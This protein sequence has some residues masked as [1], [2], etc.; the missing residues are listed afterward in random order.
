M[1]PNILNIKSKLLIL[2]ILNV[3]DIVFTLLLLETGFFQEANPFMLYIINRPTKLLIIKIIL[4]A[5]LLFLMYLRIRNAQKHQLII[6]NKIINGALFGYGLLNLLHLIWFAI[7]PIISVW[8]FSV[9][10]LR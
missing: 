1:N 8:S 4:P 6:S 9:L 3:L 10:I 5:L 2:Y 7:I